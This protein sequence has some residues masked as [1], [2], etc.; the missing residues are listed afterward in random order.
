MLPGAMA[1]PLSLDCDDP[2]AQPYFIWD[3]EITYSE[4]RRKLQSPDPDERALWMGRVMRE[5][6]YDDV[7]KL[8]R[9]RD[10]LAMLPRIDR[11]LGRSRAFWHWLIE[12]WRADGLIPR[13]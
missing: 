5:A 1:R 4:L 7:W 3:E 12:G 11:H 9:L 13:S 2:T 6:R 8:L 10:V